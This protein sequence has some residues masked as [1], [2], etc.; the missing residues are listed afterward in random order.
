A[1]APYIEGTPGAGSERRSTPPTRGTATDG[2]APRRQRRRHPHALFAV[3]SSGLLAWTS[4]AR[5][6]GVGRRAHPG[7][8]PHRVAEGGPVR[9]GARTPVHLVDDDRAQ[10]RRRPAPAGDRRVAPDA[11]PRR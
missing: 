1:R 3:R 10:P 6:P 7:R 2:R 8:L 4:P 11:G 9:P 5:N